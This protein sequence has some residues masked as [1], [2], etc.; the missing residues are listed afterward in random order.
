MTRPIHKEVEILYE[1]TYGTV[2]GAPNRDTN[3]TTYD[4]QV[5]CLKCLE[6]MGY[7]IS[8]IGSKAKNHRAEPIQPTQ[9]EQGTSKG[10]SHHA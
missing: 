9:R 1:T 4:P 3:V 8:S 5:T 7:D 6:G 2:C 10:A